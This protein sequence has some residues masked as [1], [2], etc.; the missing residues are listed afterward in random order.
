[1]HARA[2]GIFVPELDKKQDALDMISRGIAK[3]RNRIEED[4]L[5]I[6]IVDLKI[7]DEID[8]TEVLS[9]HIDN[10]GQ[11]SKLPSSKTTAVN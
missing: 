5:I 1:M 2:V 7:E 9:Y 10:T 6:F 11:I 8:N 3:Q 4:Y